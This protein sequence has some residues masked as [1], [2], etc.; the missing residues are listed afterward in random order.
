MT[1]EE[2]QAAAALAI[3]SNTNS[4]VY[5]NDILMH[6]HEI[7]FWNP[8]TNQKLGEKNTAVITMDAKGK[9][10]TTQVD[11]LT[12]IG[13]AFK[14]AEANT[15]LLKSA[16]EKD[17]LYDFNLICIHSETKKIL[18]LPLQTMQKEF[19]MRDLYNAIDEHM[20]AC[21]HSDP[22]VWSTLYESELRLATRVSLDGDIMDRPIILD[23]YCPLSP[24]L[25]L[26]RDS[27]QV[28]TCFAM[29][30]GDDL[31]LGT[32]S[33]TFKTETIHENHITLSNLLPA[34]STGYVLEKIRNQFSANDNTYNLKLEYFRLG[35]EVN[36]T[37]KIFPPW[38]SLRKAGID[39][40]DHTKNP[41]LVFTKK[42][43][44]AMQ[45]AGD[46][47]PQLTPPI[48]IIIDDDKTTTPEMIKEV[49]EASEDGGNS[50]EDI[51]DPDGSF[52]EQMLKWAAKEQKELNDTKTLYVIIGHDIANNSYHKELS[53]MEIVLLFFGHLILLVTFGYAGFYVYQVHCQ[54]AAHRYS[55]MDDGN[56]GQETL[57]QTAG[58]QTQ[59]R[60]DSNL[61]SA[62]ASRHTNDEK[63]AGDN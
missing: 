19:L 45:K 2:L 37:T 30:N 24:E 28:Q 51:K 41:V 36:G 32:F 49:M 14:F 44:L 43:V 35:R 56:D 63:Q 29:S 20:T 12:P 60:L 31:F 57:T 13:N 47:V 46:H 1:I 21:G 4:N 55:A 52:R 10:T 23:K 17:L 26:E 53:S 18:D 62:T 54:N 5:A 22:K 7:R 9:R 61:N 6:P 15:V 48:K 42:F 34:H 40:S 16:K 27:V 39:G 50:E 38:M 3:Y 11:R 8:I 58:F 25:R 33:T 59:D